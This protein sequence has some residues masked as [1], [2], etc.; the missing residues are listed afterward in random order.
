MK[1][2]LLLIL[3]APLWFAEA[4]E[5]EGDFTFG[6]Y[7]WVIKNAS[8]PVGPGPNRYSDRALR[9]GEGEVSLSAVPRRNR[10]L[11]SE[12]YTEELFSYGTF[13]LDFDLAAPL[14]S[15]AVFGFFLYNDKAPP[16]Y[17]EIDFEISRWGIADSLPYHFSVQ[18]YDRAGNSRSF[19]YSERG[20]FTCRIIWSPGKVVITLEGDPEGNRVTWIYQGE[21]IPVGTRARVHMNLWL[22]Q[23]NAPAGDG[24]LEVNVRNFSFTAN[25]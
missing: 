6:G 22:F 18:P 3:I 23:G 13:E 10:W 5:R 2:F 9:Q 17:N 16:S 21:D 15:H 4:E 14:D 12:I 19:A 25:S 1:I 24:A 11:C 7:G 8:R 20:R